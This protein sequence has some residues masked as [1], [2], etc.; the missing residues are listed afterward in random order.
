M[1]RAMKRA[2]FLIYPTEENGVKMNM[3]DESMG[4]ALVKD[5]EEESEPPLS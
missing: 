1:N 4:R 3:E 5:H 2:I